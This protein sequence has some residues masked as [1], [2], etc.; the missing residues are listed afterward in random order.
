MRKLA[1][2]MLALT[3]VV[4]LGLL[5]YV[6]AE[7]KGSTIFRTALV[8]LVGLLTVGWIFAG[9]GLQRGKGKVR[10]PWIEVEGSAEVRDRKDEE[11]EKKAEG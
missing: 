11:K 7:G 9:L 10:A 5:I 1:P 3:T 4:A 6:L 8:V 2:Y